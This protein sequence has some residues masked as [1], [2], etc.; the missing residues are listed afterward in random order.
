MILNRIYCIVRHP[1]E[2]VRQACR[3]HLAGYHAMQTMT[4][5]CPCMS[6]DVYGQSSSDENIKDFHH[7]RIEM[8]LISGSHLLQYVYENYSYN[9]KKFSSAKNQSSDSHSRL[10]I[11]KWQNHA[12]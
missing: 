5:I 11:H 12:F 2:C 7:R 3:I 9:L 6:S 4:F 8:W 10:C 1:A